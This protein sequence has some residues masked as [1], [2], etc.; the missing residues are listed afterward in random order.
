MESAMLTDDEL[1]ELLEATGQAGFSEET[2]ASWQTEVFEDEL[3]TT[4]ELITL[5]ALRREWRMTERTVLRLALSEF[6]D[7]E[8]R[9]LFKL[10]TNPLMRKWIQQLAVIGDAQDDAFEKLLTTYAEQIIDMRMSVVTSFNF[11]QK[12]VLPS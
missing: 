7:E 5:A 10:Q 4:A 1:D 6:S 11:G 8:Q 12:K 2:L 9:E 3:P